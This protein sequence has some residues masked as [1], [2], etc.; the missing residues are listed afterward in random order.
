MKEVHLFNVWTGRILFA[1]IPKSH[2]KDVEARNSDSDTHLYC[3]YKYTKRWHAFI[4]FLYV[5]IEIKTSTQ[6]LNESPKTITQLNFPGT[7]ET[8]PSIQQ[9][10]DILMTYIVSFHL[11]NIKNGLYMKDRNINYNKRIKMS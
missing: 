6:T 11:F 9:H 5:E 1:S 8:A 10:W 3:C 2:A 4:T 7:W